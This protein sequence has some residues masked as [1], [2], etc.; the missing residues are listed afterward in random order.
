MASNMD[1]EN[2]P[3]LQFQLCGGVTVFGLRLLLGTDDFYIPA[4]IAFSGILSVRCILWVLVT[5][6]LVLRYVVDQ[7]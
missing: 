5:D 7:H 3:D 1:G 4:L 6:E 2:G